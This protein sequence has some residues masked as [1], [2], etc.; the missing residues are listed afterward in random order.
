MHYYYYYYIIT[1]N[2]RLFQQQKSLLFQQKMHNI[3]IY[4]FLTTFNS[5]ISL[6]CNKNK[7]FNYNKTVK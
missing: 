2:S 7:L 5:N 1:S 4:L 6:K 3:F